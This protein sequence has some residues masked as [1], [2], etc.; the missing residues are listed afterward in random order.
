MEEYWTFYNFNEINYHE[1]TQLDIPDKYYIYHCLHSLIPNI[2]N[3]YGFYKSD[4]ILNMVN[5]IVPLNYIYKIHIMLDPKTLEDDFLNYIKNNEVMQQNLIGIKFTKN[6]EWCN[7]NDLPYIVLYAQPYENCSKYVL[8]ECVN[9]FKNMEYTGYV[10]TYDIQINNS[11]VCY[12]GGD[13][14]LKN[15]FNQYIGVNNQVYMELAKELFNDDWT[16]FKNQE[17]LI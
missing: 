15:L 9:Y 8:E 11:P 4:D 12:C 7:V 10:P 14:G 5:K 16:L 2:I 6:I 1:T 17:K 13:R 3:K